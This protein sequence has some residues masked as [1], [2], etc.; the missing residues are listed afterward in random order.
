MKCFWN[1][2]FVEYA[3]ALSP[4]IIA[5]AAFIIGKFTGLIAKFNI[6][7]DAIIRNTWI[8]IENQARKSV[9]YSDKDGIVIAPYPKTWAEIENDAIEFA[10][11]EYSKEW[12]QY[13]GL[14]SK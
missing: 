7:N 14:K 2:S 10:K 6:K 9:H 13:K 8:S 3:S 5:I 11:V 12:E 4:Y 1:G